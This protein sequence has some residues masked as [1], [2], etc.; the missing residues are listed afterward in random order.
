[1]AKYT[2]ELRDVV[3][4]HNIFPF[5]YEFY[6][7][8]KKEKFEEDFI[9]HFYFREIGLETPEMFIHYLADKMETVF[10]YYNTLLKTAE[11]EYSYL[12]NYD[13]KEST[14]IKRESSG[15]ERGENS[16]VGQAFDEQ[17]TTGTEFRTSETESSGTSANTNNVTESGTSETTATGK[18]TTTGT[19]SESTETNEEV[20][21]HSEGTTSE[22]GTNTSEGLVS[23]KFLDTP[24]GMTNLSDSKYITTLN[25]DETENTDTST[26]NTTN[27]TD[28]TSDKTGETTTSGENDSETNTT[29]SESGETS[30][31]V[32]DTN[33]GNTSNTASDVTTGETEGNYTSEQKTTLDNN[34]RKTTEGSETEV[35]EHYRHGNIG[36]QTATDMIEKHIQLQKTL[37]R[38]KEMF[39]DE[40]E[41]LF[42][43]VY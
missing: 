35:I 16:S 18:D 2:M 27:D 17:H 31:T 6:D 43:M 14:T 21:T 33:S 28:G 15:S 30:R 9:R 13:M 38:I 36:V 8:T 40:C 23:K 34:T 10:P 1:M 7:H 41:D 37:S 42:M 39:F 4:H 22:T 12:E 25:I 20:T 29:R 19:H 24:Q 26:K 32:T 3:K 5:R 11:T